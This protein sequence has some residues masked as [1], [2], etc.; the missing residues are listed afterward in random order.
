MMA[1]ADMAASSRR[2]RA[3]L[4]WQPAGPGLLEEID[5]PAYYGA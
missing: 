1:G 2:T 4:N 3:L 5:Q